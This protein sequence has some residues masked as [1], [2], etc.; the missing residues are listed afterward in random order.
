[1]A[2]VLEDNKDNRCLFVLF[3]IK[4]NFKNMFT[5]HLDLV[6]CMY[7]QKNYTLKNFPFTIVIKAWT[8]NKVWK[9]IKLFIYFCN[10]HHFFEKPYS[11]F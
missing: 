1:M 2:M 8:T 6:G 7:A 10:K 9:A 4:H 3:F 5:T 11:H